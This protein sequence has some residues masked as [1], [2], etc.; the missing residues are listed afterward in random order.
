M[1]SLGLGQEA[2]FHQ[3]HVQERNRFAG[4]LGHE[5]KYL[6]TWRSTGRHR[7]TLS[8]FWPSDSSESQ[9]CGWL[10]AAGSERPLIS[11]DEYNDLAR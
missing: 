8:L 2:E 7:R 3:L 1:A 10:D 9:W 11:L 5:A 4:G 6:P